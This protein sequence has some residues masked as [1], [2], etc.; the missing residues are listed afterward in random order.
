MTT[1]FELV[2]KYKDLGE[3]FLPTRGTEGSAGYDFRCAEDTVVP[4]LFRLVL[5]SS[6][7]NDFRE[8]ADQL[9]G[10]KDGMTLDDTKSFLKMW[11]VRPTLVPTGIKAC[12]S[13]NEYLGLKARSSTPLNYLLIVANG[14]GIIDSDYYNNP[15]NEGHIYV[16]L[17]NLA[18]FDILVRKGDKIAQGI[19]I[20][21]NKTD[22][23]Y[24]EAK[25]LSG[26]GSTGN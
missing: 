24:S 21:Y 15:D 26:F 2:T 11:G 3:E 1:K 20:N 22:N 13:Q 25:R 7:K 5:E 4:S 18:P 23:D 17:I 8:Q 14:E 12:M 6:Q 9:I 10:D 16:Q 19:F